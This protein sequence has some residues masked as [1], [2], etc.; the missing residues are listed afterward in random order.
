MT[1]DI[2]DQ[3]VMYLTLKTLALRNVILHLKTYQLSVAMAI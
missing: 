3:S 2:V 1:D